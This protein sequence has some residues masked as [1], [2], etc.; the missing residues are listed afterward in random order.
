VGKVRRFQQTLW[1]IQKRWGDGV[2]RK[3]SEEAQQ[4]V[5]PTGYPALDS[6]LS[7]GGIP[8]GQMTLLIGSATSGMTTLAHKIIAN[9]KCPTV[10]LDMGETF[11]A[12]YATQCGVDLDKLL[13]I[14]PRNP[15]KA[16]Q[17]TRDFISADSV[18]VIVLDA[19]VEE[20]PH[21]RVSSQFTPA[22]QLLMNPLLRSQVA[23][24]CLLPISWQHIFYP[25]THLALQIH[26]KEWQFQPE[27]LNGCEAQVCV[28]KDKNGVE[29]NRT[30]IT[31]QF[32]GA[33]EGE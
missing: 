19:G 9:A 4:T 20:L 13:L 26:C 28:L 11:D 1:D 7:T 22:L 21:Q 27:N 23:L 18:G 16:F 17:I 29:G 14:R 33:G 25:H 24:L 6:L 32:D 8:C 30:M 2:I 5:I 15:I 12:H 10:Y 31:I 3:A